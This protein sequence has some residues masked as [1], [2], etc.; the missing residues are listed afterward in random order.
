MLNRAVAAT[1]V[2]AACRL[3]VRTPWRIC[4][5]RLGEKMYR[6]DIETGAQQRERGN[7]DGG[8]SYYYGGP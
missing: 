8:I 7:N 2:G 6:G 5:G 3:E 4:R 1:T